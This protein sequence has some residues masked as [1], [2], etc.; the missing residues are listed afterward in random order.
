[1]IVSMT[2]GRCIKGGEQSSEGVEKK[3][4]ARSLGPDPLSGAVSSKG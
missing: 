1:M 4:G 2:D 3:E